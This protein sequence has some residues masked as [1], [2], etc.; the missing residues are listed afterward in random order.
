MEDKLKLYKKAY[1]EQK[2]GNDK[3]N[4]EALERMKKNIIKG[5]L[6][7][8]K[9]AQSLQEG[10]LSLK[11]TEEKLKELKEVDNFK[12]KLITTLLEQK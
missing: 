10:I 5:D 4:E 7:K 12:Q 1:R 8:I 6:K 2:E 9:I 11:K 3:L